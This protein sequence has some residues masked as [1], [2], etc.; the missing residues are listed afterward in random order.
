MEKEFVSYTQA[1]ALKELG[2]DEPC[3]AYFDAEKVFKFPGTTMYNRNFLGLFTVTTPLYQQAFRWFRKK[4]SLR[5]SIIDDHSENEKPYS[6][7]SDH[8]YF[9]DTGTGNDWFK[10]YEEA[11]SACLDKLIE[12]CKNKDNDNT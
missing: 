8:E 6:F 9:Y 12:I 3:L 4:H 1:L 7:T 2:F 11:E 5:F 10:T